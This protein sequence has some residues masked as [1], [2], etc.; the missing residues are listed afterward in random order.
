MK[1]L[2]CFAVAILFFATSAFAEPWRVFDNAGLFTNEEI[3]VIEQAIFDF[4]R[5]NNCDFA[6][7][8][9]DDYLGERNSAEIAESFFKSINLGLGHYKNGVLFYFAINDGMLMPFVSVNGEMRS[10]FEVG[11]RENALKTCNPFLANG[12][13]KN[14]V[15]LMIEKATEACKKDAK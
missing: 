3:E 6:V 5:K 15:L 13:Y 11:M 8:S 4:Q 14:A 10:N 1:R 9:T 2:F 12:E 7:L